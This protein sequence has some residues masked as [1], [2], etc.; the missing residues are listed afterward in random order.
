VLV[1]KKNV[2]L[3]AQCGILSLLYHK[4][5]EGKISLRKVGIITECIIA[6]C[7]EEKSRSII[8]HT[9]HLGKTFAIFTNV[10][11]V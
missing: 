10:D 5:I 4:C 6:Y 9:I 11:M 8:H 1:L 2:F 3:A 7:V